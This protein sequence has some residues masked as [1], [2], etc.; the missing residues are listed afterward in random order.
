METWLA[1]ARLRFDLL[2]HQGKRGEG[3]LKEREMGVFF[4][5][6]GMAIRACV[7]GWLFC[8]ATEHYELNYDVNNKGYNNR[9][10][11]VWGGRGS[12]GAN[13]AGAPEQPKK[14]N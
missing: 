8:A 7:C 4:W 13:Q 5:W 3:A 12:L 2:V 1:L 9:G 14:P 11:C 10:V 6:F